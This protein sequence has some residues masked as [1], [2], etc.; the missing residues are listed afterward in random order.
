MGAILS[1][2]TGKLGSTIAS[3]M[4]IALVVLV[5]LLGGLLAW[6]KHEL[7]LEAQK[8]IALQIS[9]DQLNKIVASQKADISKIQQI[10]Q[11]LTDSERA[12]S[13]Q[14][15]SLAGKLGKLD[16]VAKKKPGLVTKIINKASDERNRCF[17]LATGAKPV[18]NEK[19]S[20]CP[21]LVN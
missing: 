12:D 4:T 7:K 17:A 11:Q 5:L 9:V 16:K 3:Y 20:V 15:V 10:N 6:N 2:M 19:N 18:K 14:E 8:N 1:W 21:Q 13:Q